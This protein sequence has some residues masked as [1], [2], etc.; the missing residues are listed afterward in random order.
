MSVKIINGRRRYDQ[1]A[2]NPAGIPEDVTRCVESVRE[3]GWHAYQCR[4]KRGHGPGLYCRQHDPAAK[5]HRRQLQDLRYEVNETLKWKVQSQRI[6]VS[7]VARKVF[8]QEVSLDELE[9]EVDELEKLV[10][11]RA[12]KQNELEEM[13]G[14]KS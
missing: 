11:A 3:S 1:W 12:A 13:E 14:K 9:R 10:A 2:G 7:E 8:R 4:R 6:L 5:N